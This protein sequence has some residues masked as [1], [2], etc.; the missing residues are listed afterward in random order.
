MKI[1]KLYNQHQA[2]LEKRRVNRKK[3]NELIKENKKIK[4]EYLKVKEQLI[5]E[6]MKEMEGMTLYNICKL[7]FGKVD[8]RFHNIYLI[9]TH[10][11]KN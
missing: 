3:S 6:V 9:L 2:F 10:K 8:S 7:E 4:L 11:I 5:K 1:A